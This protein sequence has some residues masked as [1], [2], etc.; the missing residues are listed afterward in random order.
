MAYE[1]TLHRDRVM[2][3]NILWDLTENARKIKKQD[4]SQMK[5]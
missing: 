3:Q 2:T 5:Q 1:Q 4:K